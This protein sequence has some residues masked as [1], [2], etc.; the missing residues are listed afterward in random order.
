MVKAVLLA[1]LAFA[2]PL[3]AQLIYA[4]SADEGMEGMVGSCCYDQDGNLVSPD[5]DTDAVTD[6]SP[7]MEPVTDEVDQS[8]R[9]QAPTERDQS[10]DTPPATGPPLAEHL[11][12]LTWQPAHR[13][14]PAVVPHDIGTDTYLIT[15]RL[16]L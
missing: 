9:T 5:C 10:R 8:A 11:P 4:C 13:A 15:R 1:L 7:C 14:V 16:R 12:A 3:Q 6:T 2:G